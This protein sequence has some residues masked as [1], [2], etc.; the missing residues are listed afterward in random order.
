M[1]VKEV[2]EKYYRVGE[3]IH[4]LEQKAFKAYCSKEE[5]DEDERHRFFAMQ[6]V[7][8][9]MQNNWLHMCVLFSENYE[10]EAERSY[11]EELEATMNTVSKWL[12]EADTPAGKHA[13]AECLQVLVGAY[14][15]EKM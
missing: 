1:K 8:T 6:R 10:A 15:L 14:I 12:N 9:A 3:A 7:D 2:K 11:I 13:Y 5:N 4:R